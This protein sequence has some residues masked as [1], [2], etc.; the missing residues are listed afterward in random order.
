MTRDELFVTKD[1][2]VRGVNITNTSETENLVMLKHFGPNN[3]EAP[4]KKIS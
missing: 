4:G 2:A 3:A 1:A